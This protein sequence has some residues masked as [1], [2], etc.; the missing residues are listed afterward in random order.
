MCLTLRQHRCK[1]LVTPLRDTQPNRWDGRGARPP[2]GDRP[3]HV[4]VTV[5]ASQGTHF[6]THQDVL[7]EY[8]H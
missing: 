6:K 4:Q 8:G 1:W 5:M 2:W 3:A 7:T